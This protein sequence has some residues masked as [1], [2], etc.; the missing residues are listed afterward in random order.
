[1]QLNITQA[2]APEESFFF[3]PIS[4]K[5]MEIK[6]CKQT[7]TKWGLI[8]SLKIASFRFNQAFSE[9]QMEGFLKDLFSNPNVRYLINN[10]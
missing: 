6:E 7:L 3:E 2:G 1:M 8:D 4:N 10:V 9:F 5:F